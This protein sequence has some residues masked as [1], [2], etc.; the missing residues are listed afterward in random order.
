LLNPNPTPIKLTFLVRSLD[1]GGA[2][3]QL[4]SLAKALDKNRFSVSVMA[5]YPGPLEQE[6][7]GSGVQVIPLN[8]RGRWEIFGFLRRLTYQVRLARPDVL[9]GYL[10]I[11]NLLALFLKLF[12]RTRVVWGLRASTIEL[13]HYDWLHRLASRLERC[14]S[15]WADLIIINSTLGLERHVARGFPRQKMLVIPNGFD[16]EVFKPDRKAGEK[17]RG[18]WGVPLQAKLVGIVGRLDPMKDHQNFLQA[19]ALVCRRADD[20]AIG[21]VSRDAHDARFVCV[22]DGPAGYGKE[23]KTLANDLGLADKLIW[24]GATTDVAAVY[25]ALD[26]LVSASRAEGLPN[27]VGEAMACGVPC[28][29]TDVGD[30][31]RLVAEHGIVVPP[32]NSGALAEGIIRCLATHLTVCGSHARARIF[33]SFS[34]Q[35][36][37]EL[38][39]EAIVSLAGPRQ[40]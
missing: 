13:D 3:R 40:E 9:H 4:I 12:V 37:A 27:V 8:K 21:L 18:E 10:D 17:L 35:R 36:L 19:A 28:V 39:E 11:P 26:V 20:A 1:Y 31:G 16:T 7:V 22:G 24:Q 5:F 30:S 34:L 29:V 33:E 38:S 15:G 14:F 32:Q 23:L 2:Q 25:N 6:L